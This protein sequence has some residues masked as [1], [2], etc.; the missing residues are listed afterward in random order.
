LYRL[1]FV[2]RQDA[3][4]GHANYKHH[5]KHHSNYAIMSWRT[6][7]SHLLVQKFLVAS[8]HFDVPNFVRAKRGKPAAV[9]LT[10]AE[11]TLGSL[12]GGA[13][14]GLMVALAINSK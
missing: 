9:P 13:Y 5:G 12:I 3:A 14:P 6:K 11:R 7:S 4:E 1:S 8:V 2:F 10:V